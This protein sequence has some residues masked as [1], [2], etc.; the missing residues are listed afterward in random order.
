[1]S[2]ERGQL[3]KLAS[4]LDP[5]RVQW[6][7]QDGKSLAYLEGWFVIHEA[8]RIFGYDGWDR[9]MVQS[10]RVFSNRDGREVACGYLARV[11]VRVRMRGGA[12]VREGTGF[13]QATASHPGDAHERALKAAETDATK[14][15]L[16]TF[17]GRFGL[18]LHDKDKDWHRSRPLADAMRANAAHAPASQEPSKTGEATARPSAIE[19]LPYWIVQADGTAFKVASAQS[20]CAGLRQLIEAAS[21]IR[22]VEHIRRYNLAP[23]DRLRQLPELTSQRGAHYADILE[24][25]MAARLQELA[26]GV[27]PIDP[28]TADGR[29]DAGTPAAAVAK[30]PVQAARSYVSVPP[31]PLARLVERMADRDAEEAIVR[32]SSLQTDPAPDATHAATQKSPASVTSEPSRTSDAEPVAP[33][34]RSLIS[35]GFSI[36]KSVLAMASDRRLRSKAHLALVA[37]KPCLVCEALPCHAHHITFAQPRGLSQKVSDEYT[38][39]LCASHHNE[40]HAFGNEA[41][42][43]RNQRI[44][45]LAKAKALWLESAGLQVSPALQNGAA[46][47]AALGMDEAS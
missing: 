40:L 28:S 41:S 10:E 16:A 1:M 6:R 5:N 37:S 2:L 22:E 24:A 18:L 30:V 29:G 32:S 4:P 31:Y 42:W 20:F 17:G 34:R 46:A 47:A 3:K 25:L 11:R 19:T 43:W 27:V 15:A 33:T 14:R 7:E 35:G 38:V 12:I 9:E 44:E 39:P 8:N 36:D 23:L 13:G 26:R 21:S 45:P